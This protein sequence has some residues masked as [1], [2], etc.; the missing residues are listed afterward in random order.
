[1]DILRAI[2][3]MP[4]GI[5]KIMYRANINCSILKSYLKHL[6]DSKLIIKNGEGR[7]SLYKITNKG[8]EVLQLYNTFRAKLNIKEVNWWAR[9]LGE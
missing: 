7:G 9:I 3:F 2:E 5:T 8:R 6:L 4:L 1:M